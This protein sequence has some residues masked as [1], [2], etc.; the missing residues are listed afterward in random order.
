MV[1]KDTN[2]FVT[3]RCYQR[4]LC[5]LVF[6]NNLLVV[7]KEKNSAFPSLEAEFFFFIREKS[8]NQKNI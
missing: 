6:F 2:S 7:S 3:F 1:K 8:D 4:V 5:A